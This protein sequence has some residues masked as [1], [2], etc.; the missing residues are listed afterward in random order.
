MNAVPSAHRVA[1]ES[2]PVEQLACDEIRE[3][4]LYHT[5]T[6]NLI[7]PQILPLAQEECKHS[8]F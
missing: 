1:L 2:R 7:A 6:L 8:T 4:L 3:Q 5:E